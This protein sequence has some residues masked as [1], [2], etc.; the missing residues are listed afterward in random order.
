MCGG[1]A[2]STVVVLSL[3]LK[4]NRAAYYEKLQRIR[5][6][7]EWES[8]LL[9]YLQ[10]VEEVAQQATETIAKLLDMFGRHQNKF[11]AS[12]NPLRQPCESTIC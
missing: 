11:K 2:V 6:H 4:Q 5:T 10:G 1:C 8:W 7:G 12:A 9:F 3:H